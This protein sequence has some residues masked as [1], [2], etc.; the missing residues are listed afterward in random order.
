MFIV[1]DIFNSRM[2]DGSAG[3]GPEGASSV[4]SGADLSQGS[5]RRNGDS[6]ESSGKPK[7]QTQTDER[8]TNRINQVT[9]RPTVKDFYFGK[10]LGEGS[11]S[12]VYLAKDVRTQNEY[13]SECHQRIFFSTLYG[14]IPNLFREYFVV[15]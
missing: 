3:G 15:V 6:N 9:R 1:K 8:T 2:P 13:A 11:F 5:S 12:F 7:D 4:S 10:L 14:I